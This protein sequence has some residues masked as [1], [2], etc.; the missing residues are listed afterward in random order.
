V[1][2]PSLETRGIL[3]VFIGIFQLENTYEN[4]EKK[5]IKIS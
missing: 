4:S 3:D 5:N 1:K 2:I